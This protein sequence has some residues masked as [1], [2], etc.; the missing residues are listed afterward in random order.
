VCGL[1]GLSELFLSAA[2]LRFF[3]VRVELS[4]GSFGAPALTG[5]REGGDRV[6]AI[7]EGDLGEGFF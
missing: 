2:H 6:N 1:E 7:S 3:F 4:S 5:R